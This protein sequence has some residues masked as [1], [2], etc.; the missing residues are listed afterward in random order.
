MTRSEFMLQY[1]KWTKSI[2]LKIAPPIEEKRITL[3]ICDLF[4][5]ED[6]LIGQ[7]YYAVPIYTDK[8]HVFNYSMRT[9]W[10]KNSKG[11]TG[12]ILEETYTL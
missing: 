10:E 9:V 4:E 7:I 5:S 12:D 8:L 1:R 3:Y 6:T 2:G 11:D